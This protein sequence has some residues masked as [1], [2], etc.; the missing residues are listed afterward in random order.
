MK[1]ANRILDNRNHYEITVR[2]KL[3]I[4]KQTREYVYPQT[5]CDAVQVCQKAWDVTEA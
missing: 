3:I 4:L 2:N 5:A 1:S